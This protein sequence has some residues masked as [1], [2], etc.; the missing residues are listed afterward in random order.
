M[1]IEAQD[2]KLMVE[3]LVMDCTRDK[4]EKTHVQ[5]FEC[6]FLNNGFQGGT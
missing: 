5:F 1:A 3:D 6:V 4:R 2:Q